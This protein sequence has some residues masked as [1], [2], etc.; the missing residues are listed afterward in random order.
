MV[1]T[2]EWNLRTNLERQWRAT[3]ERE[4]RERSRIKDNRKVIRLNKLCKRPRGEK[5]ARKKIEREIKTRDR[6]RRTLSIGLNLSSK[7][8]RKQ[9][10]WILVKIK[11]FELSNLL[12]EST[13]CRKKKCL[14]Q[15]RIWREKLNLERRRCDESLNS[16]ISN[17]AKSPSWVR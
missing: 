11:T 6:R 1:S 16:V 12:L 14:D 15:W 10:Y 8:E 7:G 5:E 4:R 2:L 17:G 9:R 13:V 3:W